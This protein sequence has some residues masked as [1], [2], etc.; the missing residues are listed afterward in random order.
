MPTNVI[1]DPD[2]HDG[3]LSSIVLGHEHVE[4]GGCTDSGEAVTFRLNG[5]RSLVADGFREGNIVFEVRVTTGSGDGVTP[6][7]LRVCGGDP[8]GVARAHQLLLDGASLLEIDE[9]YGCSLVALFT[10]PFEVR[11]GAAKHGLDP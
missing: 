2:L 9:T 5:L 1:L 8:G 4:I 3:Q 11:R 7:L 6:A 10:G